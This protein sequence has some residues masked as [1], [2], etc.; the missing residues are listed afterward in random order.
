M[1]TSLIFSLFDCL[2]EITQIEEERFIENSAFDYDQD[3]CTENQ[4]DCDDQNPSVN[5]A[6]QEIC[7][8]LDNDCNGEIDDQPIDPN[9]PRSRQRWS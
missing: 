4:G 3:G 5:P 2:P 7:D 1:I 9:L 6:Q 8:Q